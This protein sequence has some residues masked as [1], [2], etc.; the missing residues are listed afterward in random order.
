[1]ILNIISTSEPYK[2]FEPYTTFIKF[3][4]KNL[5]KSE[6]FT[7]NAINA[8]GITKYFF[9][10]IEYILTTSL[11]SIDFVHLL[12]ILA[13][14]KINNVPITTDRYILPIYELIFSN[15]GEAFKLL[16][17]N[18]KKEIYDKTNI[19]EYIKNII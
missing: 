17:E 2:T 4:N 18:Y 13:F 14:S 11:E 7:L 3:S 19:L 15:R 8:G 12:K 6:G 16:Q 5:A 1:M 9:N 10:K